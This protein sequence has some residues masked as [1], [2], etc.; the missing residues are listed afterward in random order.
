MREKKKKG[1]RCRLEEK[2]QG[3]F[4]GSCVLQSNKS[5]IP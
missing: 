3:K 4:G 2:I 5:I 1:G